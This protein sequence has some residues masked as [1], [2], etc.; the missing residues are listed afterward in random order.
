MCRVLKVGGIL[1]TNNHQGDAM[2]AA[3]D[4]NF[5]LVGIIQFQKGTYSIKEVDL[6]GPRS[7]AQKLNNKYLKQVNDDVD[8]IEN[9]TYYIF[10]RT[11]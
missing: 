5:E 11:R 6:D 7:P 4:P 8:Y 10:Q 2:D 3:K 1:L 9:E